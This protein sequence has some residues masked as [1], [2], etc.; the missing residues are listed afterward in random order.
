MSA[1]D[2]TISLYAS[3]HA[4]LLGAACVAFALT[5]CAAAGNASGERWARAD[6]TAKSFLADHLACRGEAKSPALHS[7]PI[8]GAMSSDPLEESRKYESCMKT[9]GYRE[10]PN[11]FAAPET[12]AIVLR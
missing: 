9:R 1:P 5:G 4:R 11:G 7:N 12:A 10:D 3:R 8:G 2:C 6:A